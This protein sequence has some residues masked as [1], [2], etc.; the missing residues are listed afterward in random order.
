[1]IGFMVNTRALSQPMGGT[2]APSVPPRCA[3]REVF[4]T[5]AEEVTEAKV[6]FISWSVY[7]YIYR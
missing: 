4:P 3:Q 6:R 7:V 2:L 5:M 1:M